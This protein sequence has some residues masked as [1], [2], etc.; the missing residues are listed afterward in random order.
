MTVLARFTDTYNPATNKYEAFPGCAG[1]GLCDTPYTQDT[2]HQPGFAYLPYLLT[3]DYYYLEELQFWAMYDSFETNPNFRQNIKGLFQEGQIRA[4]AWDMRTVAE[5]AYITPDDDV[6]KDQLITI[7]NTNLDWYTSTYITNTATANALGVLTNGYA[8]S[9]SNANGIA[10][11]QDD[12]FTA[13]VGH[14][15]ELGFTK[16][17]PLLQWKIKFPIQRMIAP[18]ACW[19]DGAAYSLV[20][21]SSN[22]SPVYSTMAEVYAANHPLDLLGLACASSAM[23]TYLNLKVGEMTGYSDFALGYPSNMQPALAYA[24]DAGGTEGKQAWAQFMA[25]TVKPN[26]SGMPQFNIVPR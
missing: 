26:Y 13:A 10:P 2:S 17:L 23:A 16:A 22:T 5:A 12:F 21:R 19:I 25:R 24:A 3:G 11:W 14:A 4:Q 9:Y 18:G 7:V 6:L 1:A 20:I 15:Y 8:Y